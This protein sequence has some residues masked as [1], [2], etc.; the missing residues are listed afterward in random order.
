MLRHLCESPKR[1]TTPHAC[2][3]CS[4][5]GNEIFQCSKDIIGTFVLVDLVR[6][7]TQH[8]LCATGAF[9]HSIKPIHTHQA[10]L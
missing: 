8:D 10:Q 1:L 7:K 5:S 2:F 6:K 9:S 3:H 4:R